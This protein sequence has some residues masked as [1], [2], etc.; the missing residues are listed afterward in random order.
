M[1]ITR[2]PADAVR[3][4]WQTLSARD[5][6]GIADWVTDDCIYVDMPVGPTLAARGPVD[7]VKRLQVGLRDLAAY[8]NH[9]GRLVSEGD[10]VMYEH[11]E[12]WTF[13]T[14]EVVELP[15]VTVHRVEGG[16]VSLWKDYWDFGG[17]VNSAPP[18][19]LEG[20]GSADTSW[21]FDATGQI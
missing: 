15:F 17:V 18:G 6:D 4:L 1:D 5:W 9:E 21:I 7:I 12:T 10:L 8:E 14:G 11:S 3:G 20:L 19:W 16:R 13:A 2:T